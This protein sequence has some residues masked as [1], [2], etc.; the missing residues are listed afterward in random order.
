M[1]SEEDKKVRPCSASSLSLTQDETTAK[2]TV[3]ECRERLLNGNEW[4]LKYCA[5]HQKGAAGD[6]LGNA[7]FMTKRGT[8]MLEKKSQT[9]SEFPR[10]NQ[11]QSVWKKKTGNRKA[12]GLNVSY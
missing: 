3:D 12:E 5:K 10:R 7:V 1:Q 6:V 11:E 4:C 2:C 8:G 9:N